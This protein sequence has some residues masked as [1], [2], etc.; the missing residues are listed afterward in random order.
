[1]KIAEAYNKHMK[2]F[3]M[4]TCWNKAHFFA[5]AKIEVGD[6]FNIKTESFNYSAR[7]MK[8]R[9]NVNGKHWIQGNTRTRQGG[10]FTD[11]E[12]KESPYFS[13]KSG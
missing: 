10:Y 13:A 6:S 12:S 4:D 9:D 8:G 11:G 5:Q 3:K 7:R 1:M 2:Y